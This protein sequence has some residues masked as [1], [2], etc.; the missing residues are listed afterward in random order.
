MPGRQERRL[1]LGRPVLLVLVLA[2]LGLEQGPLLVLE[3]CTMIHRCFRP[4]E[5]ERRLGQVPIQER[6]Q[7]LVLLLVLGRLGLQVRL[8]TCCRACG[9]IR[10]LERQERRR[11]LGR[12]VPLVLEPARRGLGRPRRRVLERC[13][14]IHRLKV[15]VLLERRLGQVPIQ[16]R[17][18]ERPQ[19]L[20]LLLVLGRLELQVRLRTCC[21]ACG[22]IRRLGRQE[23]QLELG[24][25][26]PLVL[27]PAPLVLGQPQ[28]LELVRLRELGRQQ[29]RL[30][31]LEQVPILQRVLQQ[32]RQ[33]LPLHLRI[34]CLVCTLKH[35]DDLLP[36]MECY[37]EVSIRGNTYVIWLGC[38]R[39]G[40]RAQRGRPSYW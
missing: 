29:E 9:G 28:G 7:V 39:R 33:A 35:S 2:P 12:P 36:S 11:V 4:M 20:V 21:R 40:Q 16:E 17:E 38:R 1:E 31:G 30:Q 25:P 10:K 34:C 18:L 37:A 15:L 26:V 6:P 8:H 3:H 22:G 24:Q 27:E 23:R 32:G 5:L 19:V 14:M 13:T